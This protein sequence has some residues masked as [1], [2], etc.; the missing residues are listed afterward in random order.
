MLSSFLQITFFHTNTINLLINYLKS[1]TLGYG[2][3]QE[4]EVKNE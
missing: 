3:R 2:L 1:Y 4:R